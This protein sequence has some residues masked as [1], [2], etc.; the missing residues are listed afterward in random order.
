M[1]SWVGKKF[2]NLGARVFIVHLKK[3]CILCNPNA[4]SEDSDQ[5]ANAQADLTLHWVNMSVDMF[6]DVAS[7]F[8]G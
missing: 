4:S 5:T 7:H 2:Y 8:V 1:L 6:S 3:L